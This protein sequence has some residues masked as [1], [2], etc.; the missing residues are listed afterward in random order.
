M[1]SC[2]YGSSATAAAD[3]EI[4]SKWVSSRPML[5]EENAYVHSIRIAHGVGGYM[6]TPISMHRLGSIRLRYVTIWMWLLVWGHMSA[7]DS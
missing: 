5:L 7:G 4:C 1:A 6:E 3:K 2:I